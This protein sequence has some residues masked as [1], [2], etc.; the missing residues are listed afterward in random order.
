MGAKLT[1][2]GDSKGVRRPSI[3]G[4][5]P[6]A[7]KAPLAAGK[8]AARW[9]RQEIESGFCWWRIYTYIV[10]VLKFNWFWYVLCVFCGLF[11]GVL[12]SEVLWT[13]VVQI[14]YFLFCNSFRA[15]LISWLTRLI[16][17]VIHRDELDLH[18]NWNVVQH[19]TLHHMSMACDLCTELNLWA[20]AWE[21]HDDLCCGAAGFLCGSWHLVLGILLG[22]HSFW[23]LV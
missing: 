1:E 17:F 22:S 18:I 16:P 9:K 15:E 3:G 8:E 10:H 19:A 14:I 5:R 12:L 11:V 7:Q 4:I 2:S 21:T 13:L 23:N 20:S 6:T